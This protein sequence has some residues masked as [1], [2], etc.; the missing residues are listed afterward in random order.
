MLP[1]RHAKQMTAITFEQGIQALKGAVT[2]INAGMEP[3][4]EVAHIKDV[5]DEAIEYGNQILQNDLKGVHSV[6][7]DRKAILTLEDLLLGT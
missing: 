3:K 1:A 4:E 5:L 2:Y 6:T 7:D